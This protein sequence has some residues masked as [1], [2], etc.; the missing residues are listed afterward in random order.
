MV[1]FTRR[2]SSVQ[3]LYN[4]DG[5]MLARSDSV[6]DLGIQ[7]NSKLNFSE[8]INDISVKAIRML[9]FIVR[10]CK[11]FTNIR[12]LKALYYSYVRSKLEYG[13]LVWYPFYLCHISAL[14]NIQ[15]KFLKLLM[16]RE[17]GL[18]PERGYDHILLLNRYNVKSLETRRKCSSISFLYKLIHNAIDCPSLLSQLYFLI[19][20]PNSRHNFTFYCS[21]SRTNILIN[22]PIHV[23]CDNYN[24]ISHICDINCDSYRNILRIAG[25]N[26]N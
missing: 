7:F 2:Q 15:R 23:M 22:S 6:K 24:K 19:P 9:G 14:E 25:S 18:Y 5:D 3:F 8:H 21:Y 10:N 4:I 26:L 13:S 17:D 20:R 11:N 16:F 1:T 12:A